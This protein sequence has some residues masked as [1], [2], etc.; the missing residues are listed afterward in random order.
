[1]EPF[2]LFFP[3]GVLVSISGVSLWPLYFAGI[4]KFYPGIMHARMMIEGFMGAFVIGFLGTAVPRLTGARHFSRA[5][6]SA[7]LMLYTLSIGT[8]IAERPFAG[9]VI[10]LV[11]LLTFAVQMTLSAHRLATINF[12]MSGVHNRVVGDVSRLPRRDMLSAG[13]VTSNARSLD[14]SPG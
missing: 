1:M 10:F 12:E 8:H 9:D 5:E 14:L 7:L 3:L 2:R 13:T 11:L 4:H 6:L